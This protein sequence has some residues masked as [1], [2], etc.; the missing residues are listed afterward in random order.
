MKRRHGSV[1]PSLSMSRVCRAGIRK[2]RVRWKSERIIFGGDAREEFGF[3]L[4][5]RQRAGLERNLKLEPYIYSVIF[6]CSCVSHGDPHLI[7]PDHGIQIGTS[8]S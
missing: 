4:P 3:L 2:E 1:V 5:D 7:G 8:A 6:L